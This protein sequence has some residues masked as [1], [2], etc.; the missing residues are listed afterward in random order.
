MHCM[1][2]LHMCLHDLICGA[3]V[4]EIHGNYQVDLLVWQS[5]WAVLVVSLLYDKRPLLVLLVT[6]MC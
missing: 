1:H 2:V 5:E 3:D 4:K 6:I